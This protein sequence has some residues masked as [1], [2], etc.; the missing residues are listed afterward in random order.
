MAK[1]EPQRSCLGC[2]AVKDKGELLRFVIAPDRTLV[3]DPQ[4]KLPGRGAY[5]CWCAE[6]LKT[7]AARKQFARAFRGEV[8]TDSP[9]TLVARVMQLL[10]ER[11]GAYLALANKAG[12][13]VSGSDTVV[14]TFK[15][16]TPGVL[17]IAADLS[18]ESR[19]RFAFLAE[20]AGIPL[21]ELFTKERLGALLGKEM[22][23]VAAI[24]QG[25]FIT[26]IMTELEKYRNFVREG[27]SNH[28]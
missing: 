4:G 6:C 15:R 9:D 12:K 3:P 26:T 27:C 16:R 24:E 23:G 11:I 1:H 18:A 5:T 14:E 17:F 2:R 28:E 19:E 13:V 21:V 8:R 10:E 22:R 25:G 20:R 7:A